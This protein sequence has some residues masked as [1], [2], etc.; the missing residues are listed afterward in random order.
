MG[1]G[2][3]F[4]NAAFSLLKLLVAVGLIYWL[5]QRGSLDL[6]GLISTLKPIH[7]VIILILGTISLFLNNFRW[8]LLLRAQNFDVT[9]KDTLPLTYIGLFFN[10]AMP[11]GVGG[12][13]VK[14]YYLVKEQKERKMAAATSILMDRLIGFYGMTCLA[15]VALTFNL[16][17]LS[18]RPQLQSLATAIIA[19]FLSFSIIFCVAFSR[20]VH[21]HRFFDYIFAKLPGGALLQRFYTVIHSYRQDLKTLWLALLLSLASQVITIFLFIFAG[22]IIHAEPISWQAYTM[23]VPLGLIAMALPLAPAGLGVGQ[24]AFLVL[25]TWNLGYESTVGPAVITIYQLSFF[26]LGLIGAFLYF[27]RGYASTATNNLELS[28]ES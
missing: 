11:G 3:S 28:R 10:Y 20:R 17:V 9:T 14:G 22:T 2:F 12:D 25:F 15:L 19:V 26:L 13:V 8:Q 24:A 16:K 6:K 1:Q 21:G 18:Q 23:V 7:L 5:V 4:K 27:R